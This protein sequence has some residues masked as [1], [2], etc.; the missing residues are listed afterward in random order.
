M[1]AQPRLSRFIAMTLAL[2]VLLATGAT[3]CSN[4]DPPAGEQAALAER[5]ASPASSAFR[6]LGKRAESQLE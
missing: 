5:S 3:G 4:Q 1:F 6:N 2:S